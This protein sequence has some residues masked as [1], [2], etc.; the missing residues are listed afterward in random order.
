METGP[1]G[2]RHDDRHDV[3]EERDPVADEGGLGQRAGD[4]AARPGP[5]AHGGPQSAAGLEGRRHHHAPT[6]Q[7]VGEEDVRGGGLGAD[8]PSTSGSFAR[9]PRAG[10]VLVVRHA[11]SPGPGVLTGPPDAAPPRTAFP[12]HA[13]TVPT[14]RVAAP[15]TTSE[16]RRTWRRRSPT[17]SVGSGGWSWSRSSSSTASSTSRSIAHSSGAEPD[18]ARAAVCA[19]TSRPCSAERRREQVG[20]RHPEEVRRLGRLDA[21]HDPCRQRRAFQRGGADEDR[22]HG[23]DGLLVPGRLGS[24]SRS[25]VEDGLPSCRTPQAVARP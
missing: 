17:S 11:G 15:P 25:G 21:P 24:P 3:G 23:S 13:A 16:R 10:Q 20:G 9:L 12:P 22:Q 6:G 7:V 2:S 1:V 19:A 4:S 14:A 5:Q 8:D 18:D